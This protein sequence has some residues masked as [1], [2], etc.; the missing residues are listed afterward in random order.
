MRKS[1]ATPLRWSAE[2]VLDLA[3]G[4]GA[5]T[6]ALLRA[7]ASCVVWHDHE[8]RFLRIAQARIP[9]QDKVRFVLRDMTHLPYDPSSFD[10]VVLRDSLHWAQSESTLIR[11]V[12]ALL[13]PGGWLVITNHNFRRPLAA[14]R[15]RRRAVA[16]LLS[17]VLALVLRRKPLPTLYVFEWLT[18]RRL[19]RAGLHLSE[20]R[21]CAAADFMALAYRP[22]PESDSASNCCDCRVA[23]G[24]DVRAG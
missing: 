24:D 16:H 10:L 4:P 20:W 1:K 2:S 6:A 9:P 23:T 18:R 19:R 7:G 21:R 8:E 3:A 13:R 15:P 11:R 5:F 22:H 12:R 17:P 14:V